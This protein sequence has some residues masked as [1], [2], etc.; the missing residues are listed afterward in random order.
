V[1]RT[2]RVQNEL[3]FLTFDV[4][5]GKSSVVYKEKD[6]YW[7]NVVGAPVFLS[8]GNEFLWTSER[9][10][11]RQVYRYS[12]NGKRPRALTADTRINAS[13]VCAN[14]EDVFF[15]SETLGE[16]RLFRAALDGSSAQAEPPHISK[17]GGTHRVTMDPACSH[18]VDTHSSATVP[19][20][21]TLMAADGSELA[22]LRPADMRALEELDLQPASRYLFR[23][24]SGTLFQTRIIK[25]PNF[26]P[27]KKYPVIVQVYG[28]P[29]AQSVRNV[30]PGVT[31]DQVFANAGFVVWEM[32]NRGTWGQGHGFETPIHKHL[33]KVEL[34]DQRA[35]VEYLISLG[36]VDRERIGVNGWSYGGF[37]TLNMMLNAPDLFKAG[38]AGAPVT[39]W[40]N[41]DSIYTERYMGLPKDNAEGYA[42][43]S[44]IPRAKNLRGK[45]M[46]AHNI[47]DDNVLFQNT[48][49]M[50]QALESEGKRF[51]LSLYTQKTHGVNGA[52][53]RQMESTMLDFF[54]RSLLGQNAR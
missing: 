34:E 12:V 40:L 22:I 25:P 15:T 41:Y 1:V 21:T 9:D 44:L 7:I 17:E 2:N 20:E 19:P 24:P 52:D 13:I 35:G 32:D 37:M 11:G 39:D 51:E 38:F 48:L 14:E 27:S 36:F 50:I 42:Q 54:E 16:R 5:S 4:A 53:A 49:Q 28:G 43:S 33:G 47:E 26:D 18:Y 46:I 31:M 30:W 8:N 23:A 29:H 3:E 10:G 45:L 6:Q